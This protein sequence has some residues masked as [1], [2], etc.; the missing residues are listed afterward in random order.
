M[1]E[2]KRGRVRV[3]EREEERREEERKKKKKKKC[4]LAA[5]LPALAH[6]HTSAHKPNRLSLRCDWNAAKQAQ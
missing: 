3:R 1:R 5:L 2:K 4:F 6:W